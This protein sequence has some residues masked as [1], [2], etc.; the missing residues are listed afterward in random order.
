MASGEWVASGK[1]KSGCFSTA[2]GPQLVSGDCRAGQIVFRLAHLS[3]SDRTW[4][5]LHVGWSRSSLGRQF[6]GARPQLCGAAP[7]SPASLRSL[8]FPFLARLISSAECVGTPNGLALTVRRVWRIS[9]PPMSFR[10]LA[11]RATVAMRGGRSEWS[12]M[13]TRDES[14]GRKVRRCGCCRS[15]SWAS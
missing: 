15:T 8:R 3:F 10:R 7:L 11:F 4:R 6:T 1:L 14:L 5:R 12:R 9:T 13:R 2:G